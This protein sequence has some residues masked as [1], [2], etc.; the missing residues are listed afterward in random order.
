MQA[1]QNVVDTALKAVNAA[2]AEMKKA[3]LDENKAAWT[4]ARDKWED[5]FS[6][7]SKQQQAL[8]IL[9]EQVAANPEAF[10]GPAV[11]AAEWNPSLVEMVGYN[12]TAVKN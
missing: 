6:K 5:A 10:S 9:K 1:Q 4:K 7:F 12:A 11:G 8:N 2:A 3:T